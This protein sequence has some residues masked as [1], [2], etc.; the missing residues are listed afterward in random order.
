[1][2]D[3]G[4]S[5]QQSKLLQAFQTVEETNRRIDL[6]R[7]KAAF[8]FKQLLFDTLHDLQEDPKKTSQSVWAYRLSLLPP[9]MASTAASMRKITGEQRFLQSLQ[10]EELRRRWTNVVSAHDQ[11]FEWIFEDHAT[12]ENGSTSLGF[13]EWLLNRNGHFWLEG[14][15][16][17]GKSTLMK[18]ICAHP[19]TEKLLATWAASAN[20]RLAM[21]KYFFWHS[22]SQLEKSQ[23]G[24]LRSLLFGI[25]SKCPDLIPIVR[26]DVSATLA[27]NFDWT[28]EELL[29]AFQKL[30]TQRLPLRFCFFIDGLD[31]YGGHHS[32]LIETLLDLLSLPDVKICL[33][34][35][36][37]QPFRDAFGHTKEHTIRL[38][39]LTRNDIRTYVTDRLLHDK[40]FRVMASE[41]PRYETLVEE[42]VN[43]AEGVFLWVFLVVRSLLD[44]IRE[45]DL[46]SGLQYRLDRL[47]QNLEAFFRHMISQIDGAY[48]RSRTVRAFQ[49]TL[50]SPEPPLLALFSIIDEMEP[51]EAH[52]QSRPKTLKTYESMRERM[53]IRL[54]AR[55]KGLLEISSNDRSVTS[56]DFFRYRVVFLHRTVRDFLNANMQEIF[57]EKVGDIFEVNLTM[58]KALGYAIQVMARDTTDENEH[59][60]NLLEQ[61]CY[62]SREVEIHQQTIEL[63]SQC[64][65]ILATTEAALLGSTWWKWR[66]KK[67]A[68][69]AMAVEWSL[70]QF[71]EKEITGRPYLAKTR[72]KPLLDHALL[73]AKAKYVD[74]P[75]RSKRMVTILLDAGE[76]PNTRFND[77]TVWSRFLLLLEKSPDLINDSDIV[78][79]TRNL[80]QADADLNASVKKKEV[81]TIPSTKPTLTGRASDVFKK[82]RGPRKA[83]RVLGETKAKDMLEHMFGAERYNF[84]MSAQPTEKR[85]VL[86]KI[87]GSAWPRKSK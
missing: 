49:I 37:W 76:S 85:T 71:V 40:I 69:V 48:R 18:F 86:W 78:D 55:C 87:F 75:L 46:I 36:P 45:R 6:D 2:I 66:R 38:Q 84:I 65:E 21:S 24:L 10:F 33:S 52:H 53:E 19:Q 25:L 41:D 5:Q 47:P 50:A 23:E 68:F 42:V 30:T 8:E 80:I 44:G 74:E 54:E 34:S 14:K 17:S 72:E 20:K 60:N 79:I 27:A 43:R 22:G 28:R 57:G 73:P 77:A 81:Y 83:T 1:M 11:T 13:K 51:Q 82:Q 26:P 35:R 67:T 16:G 12:A 62:H 9:A 32:E 39:D 63:T 64:S 56:G 61:L 29:S 15:A 58:C 4:C 7:N 31:E 59:C 70:H 3:C